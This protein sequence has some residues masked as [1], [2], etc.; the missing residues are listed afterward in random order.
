MCL[1]SGIG[2]QGCG[3]LRE[4]HLFARDLA[5]GGIDEKPFHEH[6]HTASVGNPSMTISRSS[7]TELMLYGRRRLSE[8]HPSETTQASVNMNVD[9]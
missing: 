9:I 1:C 4:G 5:N 7:F 6:L 3:E 8:T 2:F